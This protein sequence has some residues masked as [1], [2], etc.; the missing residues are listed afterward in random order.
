MNIE[1]GWNLNRII[2]RGMRCLA[3]L[4]KVIS[5]AGPI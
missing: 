2:L 4:Q 5:L 3:V 1:E